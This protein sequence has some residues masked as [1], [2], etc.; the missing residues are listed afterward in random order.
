V[1]TILEYVEDGATVD[2]IL[3]D[4]P[5]LEREAVEEVIKLAKMAHEKVR[6]VRVDRLI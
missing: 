4:Y 1:Q 6:S 2:E 5:H 3:E